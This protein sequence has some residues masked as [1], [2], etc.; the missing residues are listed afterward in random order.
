MERTIIGLVK[1]QGYFT[2]EAQGE[3]QMSVLGMCFYDHVLILL[4]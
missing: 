2:G 1:L 3:F 4:A